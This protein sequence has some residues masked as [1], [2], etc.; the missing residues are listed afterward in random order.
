MGEIMTIKRYFSR[1]YWFTLKKPKTLMLICKHLITEW[2][3]KRGWKTLLLTLHAYSLCPRL[4]LLA[5]VRIFK[6]VTARL[7]LSCKY[8]LMSVFLHELILWDGSIKFKLLK[9]CENSKRF[10]LL[11]YL[12]QSI[13]FEA[14]HYLW[15]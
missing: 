14:I 10:Y 1:T 5:K 15:E 12:V 6:T 3:Q 2:E 8:L 7:N 13:K 4:C 9:E 11:V